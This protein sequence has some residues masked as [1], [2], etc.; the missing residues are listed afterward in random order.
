MI[1][2]ETHTRGTNQEIKLSRELA[3]AIEQQ[4]REDPEAIPLAIREAYNR[5]YSHYVIQLQTEVL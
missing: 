5:L 3:Q 1:D 4:L 2:F